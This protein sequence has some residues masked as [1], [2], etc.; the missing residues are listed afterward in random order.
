MKIILVFSVLALG[1]A[2]AGPT[3]AQVGAGGGNVVGGGVMRI[4]G[5][6]DDMVIV[7]GNEGA[8]EGAAGP[9]GMAGRA[10]RLAAGTGDGP[11]HEYLDPASPAGGRE[12]WMVGGGDGCEVVYADPH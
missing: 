3:L 8:G 4:V 10:A 2:H 11:E 6:G 7:R 1:A 5:G 9:L 12:A